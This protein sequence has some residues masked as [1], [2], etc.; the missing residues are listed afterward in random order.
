M[1]L[2][3]DFQFSLSQQFE[4]AGQP[5]FR[6]DAARLSLKKIEWDIKNAERVSL[7]RGG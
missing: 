7:G 3:D 1:T 4:V 5:G 6:R 2:P